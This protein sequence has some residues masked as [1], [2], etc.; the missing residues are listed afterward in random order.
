M[1]KPEI[2]TIRVVLAAGET[3]ADGSISIN[4]GQ[5]IFA[6]ATASGSHTKLVRLGLDVNGSEI[7]APLSLP[8]W[9]GQIG[10]FQQR[11]RLLSYTGGSTV[12][13]KIR[14][15]SAPASDIEIEVAFEIWKA[16]VLTQGPDGTLIPGVSCQ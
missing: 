14:T 11:G 3:S 15:A 9:D 8:F 5:Q 10:T 2:K 4:E 1:N 7:H 12:D 6:A 13:L 16:P